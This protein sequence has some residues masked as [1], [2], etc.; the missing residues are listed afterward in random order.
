MVHDDRPFLS[1]T[2]PVIST[3][4]IY[5]RVRTPTKYNY[6]DINNTNQIYKDSF[7]IFRDCRKKYNYQ[8]E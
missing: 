2:S 7:N 1:S 6:Q 3:G 8:G 5:E 4:N